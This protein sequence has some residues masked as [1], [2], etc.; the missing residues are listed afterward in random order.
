[1]RGTSA[2]K[3]DADKKVKNLFDQ[4][5]AVILCNSLPPF[6]GVPHS[7]GAHFQSARQL[8]NVISASLTAQKQRRLFV[9]TFRCCCPFENRGVG[10]ATLSI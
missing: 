1:M 7:W 10:R 6:H 8:S 2:I 5:I 4:F 9:F 3:R